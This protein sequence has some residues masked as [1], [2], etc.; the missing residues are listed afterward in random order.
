MEDPLD[1]WVQYLKWAK[2]A[3]P[4]GKEELMPLLERC[5]REF[6]D[7]ARYR[8]DKRYLRVWIQY[9]RR[10]ERRGDAR[11]PTAQQPFPP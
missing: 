3:F 10:S 7:E 4:K 1:T 5:T 11:S 6:K 8:E 2:G 9:V